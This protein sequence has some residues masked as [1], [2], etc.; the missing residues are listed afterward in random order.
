MLDDRREKEVGFYS[1]KIRT[2]TKE[3][4]KGAYGNVVFGVG[5]GVCIIVWVIG[6][7]SYFFNLLSVGREIE[8][9]QT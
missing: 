3:I 5:G 7:K 1:G 8:M 2:L 6:R 9:I 4:W